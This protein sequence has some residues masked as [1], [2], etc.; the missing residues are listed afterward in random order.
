MKLLL[1]LLFGFMLIPMS[2]QVVPVPG[3]A[4]PKV[5]QENIKTTICVPG[6]TSTVRNVPKKVADEVYKRD[7]QT[8]EPGICC[9]ID[10]LI[11]LELGG[12]NDIN[13]LWAQ[14][15][16]VPFNAQRKDM[17]ENALHREVCAGNITLKE[18]QAAISKDWF[19]EWTRRFGKK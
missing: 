5:T 19:K 16:D 9:E 12:S 14:R 1:V 15:Y 13:N 3:V 11:S 10:H 4:D 6:Y 2:A 8:K 17:L 7:K 18:A